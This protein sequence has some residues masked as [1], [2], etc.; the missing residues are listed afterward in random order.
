MRLR[1]SIT[2]AVR[3]YSTPRK[4]DSNLVKH[5]EWLSRIHY[6]I[7]LRASCIYLKALGTFCLTCDLHAHNALQECVYPSALYTWTA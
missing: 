5:L 7:Q 1:G 2:R 4:G 3:H 6:T